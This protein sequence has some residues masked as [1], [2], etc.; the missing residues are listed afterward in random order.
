[1]G[2]LLD[3]LTPALTDLG[4]E[5]RVTEGV[6]RIL[7]AGTGAA[8]QRAAFA[9]AGTEGLLDLIAPAPSTP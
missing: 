1:M 7:D 9:D 6:A 3:H 2:A 5:Q 8:R 4:D